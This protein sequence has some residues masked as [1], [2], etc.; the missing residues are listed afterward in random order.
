MKEPLVCFTARIRQTINNNIEQMLVKEK[1]IRSK[2]QIVE[3]A[4]TQYYE[5]WKAEQPQDIATPQPK[6]TRKAK[7]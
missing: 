6:A 2:N 3:E 4:L 7:K 5:K 1:F